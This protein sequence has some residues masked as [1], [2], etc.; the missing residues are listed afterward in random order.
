LKTVQFQVDFERYKKEIS[1]HLFDF[2]ELTSGI[3]FPGENAALIFLDTNVLLWLY[4]INKEAREEVFCLLN[5]IKN[6]NRLCIP[7]WV[8]HEYNHHV[9]KR[10]DAAFFPFKKSAKEIESRLKIV[11]QHSKLVIDDDYLKGSKYVGK[12]N[13]LNDF[14]AVPLT[15]IA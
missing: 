1:A 5:T 11:E 9:A 13:F 7:S 15:F 2:S 3:S 14:T 10:D 6:E 4:R 8:I 12:T